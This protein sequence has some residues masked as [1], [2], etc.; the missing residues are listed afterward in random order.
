MSSGS[1]EESDVDLPPS[2]LLDEL[3]SQAEAAGADLQTF[4]HFSNG[5]ERPLI[6]FT[7]DYES[8]LLIIAGEDQDELGPVQS[9]TD[10]IAW[11]KQR[12]LDVT[13]NILP[14][15]DRYTVDD[16]DLG[17]S[18]SDYDDLKT[19][20]AG[21]AETYTV[22]ELF[23]TL[24]QTDRRLSEYVKSIDTETRQEVMNPVDEVLYH[25]S[26]LLAFDSTES[27]ANSHITVAV[28]ALYESLDET[29][30]IP[31][32]ETGTVQR[33][34]KRD[35]GDGDNPVYRWRPI[36]G[37]F[38]CDPLPTN[39]EDLKSVAAASDS[40]LSMHSYNG[41]NFFLFSEYA[42]SQLSDQIVD[43][44][45]ASDIS[46]L[47]E[48]ELNREYIGKEG[49]RDGVVEQELGWKTNLRHW[50]KEYSI[51][52]EAPEEQAKTAS[53]AA[54]IEYIKYNDTVD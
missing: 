33:C 27:A 41:E 18:V 2:Y 50:V 22:D 54:A 8:E 9:L 11:L 40:A 13:V 28:E 14:F 45:H 17:D 42:P 39:F 4:G 23:S 37:C 5:D 7:G 35:A 15:L 51:I 1:I 53:S 16:L 36:Y 44:V 30:S 48:E 10:T 31:N 29:F 43:Q 26:G 20:V 47:P 49:V 38:D 32:F 24:D 19:S 6:R 25:P 52:T 46:I 21:V 34:Y 12:D 3:L